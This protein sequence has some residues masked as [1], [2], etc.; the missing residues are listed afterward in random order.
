[1]NKVDGRDAKEWDWIARSCSNGTGP[2]QCR[3]PSEG[4]WYAEMVA[5]NLREWNRLEEEAR[6]HYLS[7]SL[8]L[9]I[10][11]HKKAARD[12]ANLFNKTVVTR[13]KE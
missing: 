1:M 6:Y 3:R 12:Y 5:K 2:I 8:Q 13:A 11:N 7:P 9:L 10:D 4:P